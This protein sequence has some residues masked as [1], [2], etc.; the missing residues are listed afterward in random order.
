MAY[1]RAIFSRFEY[2]QT[3]GIS[4]TDTEWALRPLVHSNTIRFVT[5]NPLYKYLLGREGQTMDSNCYRNQ[6]NSYI[7]LFESAIAY[8]LQFSG[9]AQAKA[10][11]LERL[12]A[13]IASQYLYA[14]NRGD[15]IAMRRF[16]EFDK[17]LQNIA[18][19]IYDVLGQRVIYEPKY[20][21]IKKWRKK[22]Y[23][24]KLDLTFFDRLQ[25]SLFVRT[26]IKI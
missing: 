12:L 13:H 6:L 1:K 3:E 15:G 21:F 20:Q 24:V 25:I 4:F 11:L 5:L 9:K 26:G 7:K 22:G 17:S 23:P 8:Y 16:A 2:K 14:N 19:Q 10:L 18:P